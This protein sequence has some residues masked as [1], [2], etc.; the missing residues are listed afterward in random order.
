MTVVS[1][2]SEHVDLV[3]PTLWPLLERAARRTP[4]LPEGKSA[5]AGR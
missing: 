2:R 1:V 3:W 4:D 5:R